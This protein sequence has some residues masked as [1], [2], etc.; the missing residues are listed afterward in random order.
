LIERLII[1]VAEKLAI[2]VI[3]SGAKNHSSI[4]QQENKEREILLRSE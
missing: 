2:S 3:L 4:E 1:Q